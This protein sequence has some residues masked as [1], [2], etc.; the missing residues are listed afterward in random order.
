MIAP[1]GDV[2]FPQDAIYF[3]DITYYKEVSLA[4]FPGTDAP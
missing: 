4:P 1:G 2:N 3:P